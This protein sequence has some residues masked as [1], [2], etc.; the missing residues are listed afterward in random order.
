MTASR[1]QLAA[2]G[3]RVPP[4]LLEQLHAAAAERGL[5]ANWLMCKL[6]T[7]AMDNLRPASEFK[8]T[9]DPK[10]LFAQGGIVPT[11]RPT[12]TIGGIPVPE[13]LAARITKAQAA[14]GAPANFEDR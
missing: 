3:L 6:L 10:P 9:K 13:H 4:A 2:T 11:P 7:E 1:P 12:L 14:T 8:L 5:T